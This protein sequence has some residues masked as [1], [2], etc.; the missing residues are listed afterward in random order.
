MHNAKTRATAPEGASRLLLI[1]PPMLSVNTPYPAM[2]GL[3]G[4][5]RNHGF[6]AAQADLSLALTL[7]LFSRDGLARVAGVLA[8]T[9]RRTTTPPVRHFL[10]H[11]AAFSAS[12]DSVIR[13]L[14]GRDPT[15]AYRLS[16]R[17]AL[18]EGPR[19]MSLDIA[20][21]PGDD[22]LTWAFGALG[23][24][25]RARHLASLYLDDLADVIH[26]G[27]DPHFELTRYGERLA[28]S[29]S[30]FAPLAA[31]LEAPPTLVDQ[32]LD[33]LVVENFHQHHPTLVGLTV[34][35]PGTLYG[36]LRI[37]RR[38]RAMRPR[39]RIVLGGGYVNTELRTL[40]EPRI[41]N[42]V[43]AVILDDGEVPL[44]R[45]AEWCAGRGAEG[46]LSRIFRRRRGRV[47]YQSGPG[48]VE[49]PPV[50][51]GTPAFEDL[52]LNDYLSAIESLTPML[53]LWSDGRW[54]KLTAA[55]G[56]YWRRCRFCDTGLPH[57]ARFRPMAAEKLADR[58]AEVIA[59]TGQ[60]GFHFVDEALPPALL[61]QLSEQL[62]AR[63]ITATWWGNIR[64]ESSF[65]PALAR[66]M[67]SAGCIAVTGGLECA[68]DRLLTLM[69][70]GITLTEAAQAC[71]ALSDAGLLVHAYLMYGF[72]TQTIR[73]TVDALEFVR[74]LFSAGCLN[75][76][77]WHRFALTVH[78][79]IAR[80][81]EAF[82]LRLTPAPHGG[83][84][85]NE[86]ACTEPGGA[87]H[88]SLGEGLRR[89]VYAYM[90]GVGIE[91][92]VTRWFAARVPRP[93]L[94]PD[95]VAQMLALNH[96][97]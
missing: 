87:D 15:L 73:E 27:V 35:F 1:T 17:G 93:T 7:R 48:D 58:M 2:P 94:A 64:F 77:F 72:P 23:V 45:Y 55:H 16:E 65:T 57:I 37:A 54:N 67:A 33:E 63:G 13:F 90:H 69:N 19:F 26:D 86:L 24:Q 89:A 40:S 25:D 52:P 49:M 34:P 39:P 44:L 71:R 96:S 56:C 61:R 20:S 91:T 76:A 82:G 29:A 81:P 10:R 4:F 36:A 38:L 6:A 51:A 88:A 92:P 68:H 12:V 30:D 8:R 22:P 42:Y 18:P 3:A 11:A 74:Q 28:V 85:C 14:Q 60:S 75:S 47:I 66:L 80:E 79:P 84:A 41:F 5:L 59:R 78:S 9:R 62:L 46:D 50:D 43:D 70:K 95:S 83:F 97:T 21:E 31:A 32:M 53:R